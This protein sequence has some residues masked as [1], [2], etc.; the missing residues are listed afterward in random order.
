MKHKTE[1]RNRQIFSAYE[2]GQKIEEIAGQYGLSPVTVCHI[3]LTEKHKQ[4][5]S[6][7]AF[8]QSLRLGVR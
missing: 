2:A 8:Y 1:G 6:P 5:V 3:I 4:A 7:D